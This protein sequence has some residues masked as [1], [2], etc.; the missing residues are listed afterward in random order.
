MEYYICIAV[1]VAVAVVAVLVTYLLC[2]RKVKRLLKEKSELE[3]SVGKFLSMLDSEKETARV[4]IEEGERRY[5]ELKA[6]DEEKYAELKAT[7]EEKYE[8]LKESDEKRYRELKDGYEKSLKDLA[9]RQDDALQKQLSAI[10]AEVKSQSEDALKAR[11]E[12]LSKRADET[13]KSITEP[14]EKELKNMKESFENNQKTQTETS[15]TLKEHLKNAVENLEKQTANIGSKADNLADALRSKNKIQGDFGETILEELMQ[16]EGFEKGVS[17][18]TQFAIKGE[19]ANS[20][21]P[22]MVVHFPDNSDVIIDSKV[23]LKALADWCD[24]GSDEEKKAASERNLKAFKEQID[25]LSKKDY[26]ANYKNYFEGKKRCLDFVLMF[27]P[28][29]NAYQLAK[30][31]DPGIWRY[32][33]SRN[34]MIVTEE[35]LVP[36]L[37]MVVLTW[38]NALQIKNMTKIVEA[39]ERMVSR[40]NS[41]AGDFGSFRAKFDALAKTYDACDKKLRDSGQS[42]IKSA[43]DVISYGVKSKADYKKLPE[44]YY[45]AE[46]E[47]SLPEPAPI[48]ET[49]PE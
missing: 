41:F 47:A 35:T 8:T 33:Y 11:Q 20:M 25:L 14:L 5:N 28:I 23:D 3:I 2:D 9:T 1:A 4:R 38:R 15:A 44:L 49:L 32:A 46:G 21:R 31:E 10:K 26:A 36:F 16:K 34:V 45:G 17:Y 40:V 18:D 24:A 27:V 43:Y 37:R 19:N 12:E 39:A 7:S 29:Y 30:I 6:S 22:D 48:P 42:I 13:F